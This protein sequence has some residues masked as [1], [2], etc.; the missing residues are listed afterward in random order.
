MRRLEVPLLHRRHRLHR[1]REIDQR[2]AR[3]FRERDDRH[4][5]GRGRTREQRI[6]LVL[7]DQA[8]CESARLVRVRGVVI[9]HEL[10][11]LAA[12]AALGVDVGDIHFQRLLLGIAEE[13]GAAGGRQH[14]ADLDLRLR[15]RRRQRRA[16]PPP[17]AISSQVS[18]FF[19]LGFPSCSD[20][21]SCWRRMAAARKRRQ[22]GGSRLKSSSS[23]RCASKN[24]MPSSRRVRD[25]YGRRG[26]AALTP[27]FAAHINYPT[28]RSVKCLTVAEQELKRK[29]AEI[30]RR[31]RMDESPI[32]VETRP[33]LS[34]R[35][36]QSAAAAEFL[37]RG[38]AYRAESG[39]RC[40]GSRF[41]LPRAC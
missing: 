32:L 7:L 22:H 33:N 25:R 23:A 17:Q 26:P 12:D 5:A 30:G 21:A 31:A 20:Q 36:A 40:G 16:P 29:S 34:H 27:E 39:A 28:D 2:N 11:L 41:H 9:D 13:R 38:H 10:D 8:G 18:W 15:K 14:R 1:A 37:H 24:A 35:H 19:S 3:L 4:A 6:D